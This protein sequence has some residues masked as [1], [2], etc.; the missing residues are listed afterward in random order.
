ML[1]VFPTKAVQLSMLK[2]DPNLDFL[3]VAT[4]LAV[5]LLHVSAV[6]VL[7]RPDVS[8]PGWWIANLANAL[9][10]WSVPVFVMISGALLRS[11]GSHIEPMK[12]YRGRALR[13][14]APLIFWTVFYVAIQ[15]YIDGGLDL[16]ALSK[17]LILGT[18]YFHLWYLYMIVGLYLVAPFLRMFVQA[19]SR[20]A[21]VLIYLITFSLSSLETILASL[22]KG[23]GNTFLSLFLP[24]V[25]YFVCGY[26][27]HTGPIPS[28]CRQAAFLTIFLGVLIALSVGAFYPFMGP[29]SWAV[30]Y[31]NF[32]PLVI[33]MSLAFFQFGRGFRITSP[34]VRMTIHWFAPL[35][36]GI[37]LIHPFWLD[38]LA[39]IGLDG[40]TLHPLLGL[41][42]TFCTVVSLSTLSIALL[43]QIPWVKST[44]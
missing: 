15:A 23:G 32:N 31:S 4:A 25:S 19:S 28:I 41:P 14:I 10:R 6:V 2:R 37:Y 3:R 30:M 44:V 7:N 12:F 5:V 39:S 18:P 27:L 11:G 36:L 24:Y 9:T 26:L 17:R 43:S 13:L 16:I 35:T 40:F 21:L 38:R 20:S 29:K 33:L 42:L 34:R 22:F 1:N 8:S